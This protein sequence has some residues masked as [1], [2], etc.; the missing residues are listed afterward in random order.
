MAV[1]EKLEK[2]EEFIQ[3]KIANTKCKDTVDKGM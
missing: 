3:P 1:K 2:I